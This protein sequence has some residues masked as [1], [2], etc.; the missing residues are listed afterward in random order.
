MH[1]E[2]IAHRST[3]LHG[4]LFPSVGFQIMSTL[5]LEFLGRKKRKK[6]EEKS[7]NDQNIVILACN[8]KDF[9]NSVLNFHS[10]SQS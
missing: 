4:I 6:K 3:G 9:L 1:L 2:I 8:L 7:K 5:N 10:V